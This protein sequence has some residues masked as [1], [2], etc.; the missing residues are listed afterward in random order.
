MQVVGRDVSSELSELDDPTPKQKAK[1]SNKVR[2][3]NCFFIVSEISA[4]AEDQD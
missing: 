1:T 4:G 3:S 2:A